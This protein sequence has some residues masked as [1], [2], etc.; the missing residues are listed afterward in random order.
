MERRCGRRSVRGEEVP[1]SARDQ[2]ER[3]DPGGEWREPRTLFGS[4]RL[5]GRRGFRLGRDAD[6]QR[7]GSD[8]PFDVLE[9]GR[10]EIGDLHVEP[11]AHL[12]VG[13][14]GETDRAGLRD[15]FESRGDI[16]AVAHQIAV[17]LLDHV[18]EMDADP[19]LDAL[20][21]R[22][23]GVALDHRPLH[24][25]GAVHCVDDTAELDDAAVA[26][27]L[28]DA[29]VMHG[30]GRIDQVAAQRPKARQNSILVRTGEPRIA[31]DV[32][33]QDR[34]EFSSL[35]HGASC[36]SRESPV[37]DGHA[38]WLHFHAARKRTWKQGV[39]PCVSTG[40]SIHAVP[41]ITPSPREGIED[42]PRL[43]QLRAPRSGQ[44]RA[45]KR[46]RRDWPVGRWPEGPTGPL[47]G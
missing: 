2:D 23:P 14:L 8:R 36:R 5:R 45:E 33:H 28:D 15:A 24:F 35:A 32:G 43:R 3:G 18:A 21:G 17:A 13:V 29:A 47:L 11:A 12:T 30:D 40:R 19:K 16:D 39:Q 22:D 1:R 6:L 7:I 9:L 26:G 41:S 31:D 46:P 20:V 34:R 25:N 37:A 27:A 10:P 44:R 42:G 4:A 38:A